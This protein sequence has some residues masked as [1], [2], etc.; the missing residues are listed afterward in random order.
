MNVYSSTSISALGI[1]AHEAGH[2]LQHAKGYAPLWLRSF[3]YP[4]SSFGSSLA[5]ILF[6][7]GIFM[8]SGLLM[9][10]GIVLYGA[11]VVFTIVTLP[12]EFNAS[13]RALAYL[14]SSGTLSSNE[15]GGAKKVL[16]AAA[17]T[18]VA[19]AAMAVLSLIR[20]LVLR[21]R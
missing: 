13:S 11:A 21:D 20:L 17:M 2:A 12:V 19:A 7:I 3:M 8:K 9:D 1:A 15:R 18:Y 5:W 10:I 14:R 16:S 6:I 4:V